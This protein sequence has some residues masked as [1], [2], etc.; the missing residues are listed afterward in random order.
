M[1]MDSYLV[2]TSN[3]L[4]VK[5]SLKFSE[6]EIVHLNFADAG[7]K[8]MIGKNRVFCFLWFF[9]NFPEVTLGKNHNLISLVGL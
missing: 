4:F 8:G 9:S 7:I 3:Q 6:A 5:D 2:G 1:N